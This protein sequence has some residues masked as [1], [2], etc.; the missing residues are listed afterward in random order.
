MDEE[1]MLKS[2]R[3]DNNRSDLNED[4]INYDEL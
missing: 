2:T 4:S 3:R 1:E